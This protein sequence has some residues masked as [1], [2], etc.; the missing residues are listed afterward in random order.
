MPN[1]E[2]V[3]PTID[4]AKLKAVKDEWPQMLPLLLKITGPQYF[5]YG[6]TDDE[7]SPLVLQ[8]GQFSEL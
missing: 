6:W 7:K 5:A 1:Q 8:I 3:I 4:P 2:I